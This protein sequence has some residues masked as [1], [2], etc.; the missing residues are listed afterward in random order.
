[1]TRNV[2]L[3]DRI[4]RAFVVAPILLV[5][6]WMVGFASV[7]GVVLAAVA[8][9]MVVTAAVAFCPLYAALHLHTD[10]RSGAP[11]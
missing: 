10:H 6:A 3:A 8:V 2:G 4:V 11:A 7:L 5:V 9:V 1:M